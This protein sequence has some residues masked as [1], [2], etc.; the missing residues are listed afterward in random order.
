MCVDDC[1]RSLC[2]CNTGNGDGIFKIRLCTRFFFTISFSLSTALPHSHAY[3]FVVVIVHCGA[4][5]VFIFY[6]NWS[7]AMS[8]DNS[9]VRI[10]TYLYVPVYI[11]WTNI[12]DRIRLQICIVIILFSVHVQLSSYDGL[13]M[14]CHRE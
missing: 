6:N 8:S 1:V 14:G 11:R 3:I 10:R 9:T 12:A 2:F 13:T 7:T 4:E 5:V